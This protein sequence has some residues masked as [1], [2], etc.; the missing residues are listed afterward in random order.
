MYKYHIKAL[1]PFLDFLAGIFQGL[2]KEARGLGSQARKIA[3]PNPCQACPILSAVIYIPLLFTIGMEKKGIR[4]LILVAN[5][6]SGKL[7]T[8]A[9]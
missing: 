2:Q 9:S 7:R 8:T 6:R 3:S 1:C 5:S 4:I